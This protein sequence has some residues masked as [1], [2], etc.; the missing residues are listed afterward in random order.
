MRNRDKGFYFTGDGRGEAP[1]LV[2][3]YPWIG[4]ENA[5]PITSEAKSW[6]QSLVWRARLIG[7]VTPWKLSMEPAPPRALLKNPTPYFSAYLSISYVQ[8]AAV[9]LK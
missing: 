3:I 9:Y 2:A 8:F 5:E 6:D 1:V 4:K 7:I